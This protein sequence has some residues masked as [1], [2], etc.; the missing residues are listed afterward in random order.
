MEF[1]SP[2]NSIT[3]PRPPPWSPGAPSSTNDATITHILP[4]T[5][6]Y[7][8]TIDYTGLL[9]GAVAALLYSPLSSSYTLGIV[10]RQL[11]MSLNTVRMAFRPCFTDVT[12]A[13]G[14]HQTVLASPPP[15]PI[16]SI[17]AALMEL[18]K[19]THS[20]A[21]HWLLF[22]IAVGRIEHPTWI[23]ATSWDGFL[24]QWIRRLQIIVQSG[25]LASN[26]NPLITTICPTLVSPTASLAQL[27]LPTPI[28]ATDVEDRF[29]TPSDDNISHSFLFP[30]T[31]APEEET[32]NQTPQPDIQERRESVGVSGPEDY[33]RLAS[34]SDLP[35]RLEKRSYPDSDEDDGHQSDEPLQQVVRAHQRRSSTTSVSQDETR[36][37][38]KKAK[39]ERLTSTVPSNSSSRSISP[40]QETPSDLQ[41]DLSLISDRQAKTNALVSLAGKGTK[42]ALPESDD[43]EA[44]DSD[45]AYEEPV[46]RPAKKSRT[47]NKPQKASGSSPPRQVKT[48][49]SR[50]SRS[51]T[52]KLG[53]WHARK[54]STTQFKCFFRDH[55]ASSTT[56]GMTFT[57]KCDLERHQV[58]HH[59]IPEAHSVDEGDLA[60]GDA[61]AYIEDL[62][63]AVVKQSTGF[64][65]TADVQGQAIQVIHQMMTSWTEPIR[66]NKRPA[67]IDL[68]GMD[69]FTAYASRTASTH[70]EHR[71]DYPVPYRA[72][73]RLR[74]HCRD[75]RLPTTLT[76]SSGREYAPDKIVD[77]PCSYTR[78]EK[79]DEHRAAKGHY[80][81][82]EHSGEHSDSN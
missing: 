5:P 29:F 37:P 32:F 35:P 68:T 71:C 42:R 23:V 9:V 49:P 30:I 46:E 15:P 82:A 12:L 52:I 28:S 44:Y 18:I 51:K 22:D 20:W 59:I 19:G 31:P 17:K 2:S 14:L 40:A 70:R 56:C 55:D 13:G 39:I 4:T 50:P 58:T 57:K 76:H 25:N 41:V 73:K 62:A 36:R 7:P 48:S 38:T 34:Q 66:R 24:E 77:C 67:S 6:T 3:T 27:E 53:T 10:V 33:T 1:P 47:S 64:Q 81:L 69:A 54:L 61:V 43:E 60:L 79:L 8:A 21:H 11:I 16:P 72:W 74:A 78:P 80:Q 75:S 26:G 45:D 63:R 65:T